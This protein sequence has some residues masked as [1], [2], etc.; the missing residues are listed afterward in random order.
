MNRRLGHRAKQHNY[1][2]RRDTLTGFL[3][4]LRT[5]FP[6]LLPAIVFLYN[7]R[8]VWSKRPLAPTRLTSDV[9]ETHMNGHDLLCFSAARGIRPARV[10]L[11]VLGL[12]RCLRNIFV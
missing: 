6:V 1:Q 2:L 11:F 5:D 12:G 8:T 7:A 9:A 4:R 3:F 10:A